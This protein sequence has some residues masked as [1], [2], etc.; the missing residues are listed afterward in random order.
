MRYAPAYTREIS[1]PL[2]GIGTGCLGLAGT[3]HLID[4][5]IFNRPGKGRFN[6]LSHFAVRAEKNGEVRDFR[7]LHGDEP[8]PYTGSYTEGD[9]HGYRGFGWDRTVKKW[10][11]GRT[12]ANISLMAKCPLPA[13]NSTIPISPARSH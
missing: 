5:E 2:G 7:L 6:G 1:F 9:A 12:F 8:P 10:R 13:W 4:W 11:G 3:G